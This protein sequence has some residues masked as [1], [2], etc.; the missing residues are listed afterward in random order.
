[1]QAELFDLEFAPIQFAA[2]GDGQRRPRLLAVS[3]CELL[4]GWHPAPLAAQ[5]L[6]SW[7]AR[8]PERW[9]ELVHTEVSGVHCHSGDQIRIEPN[10]LDA[11]RGS[12]GEAIDRAE[13]R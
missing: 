11:A 10:H 6:A 13:Q 8:A 9:L 2:T 4:C 12:I 7:L 1:M 3:D 5:W